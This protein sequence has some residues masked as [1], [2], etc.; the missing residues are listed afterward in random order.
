[1]RSL[2][3]EHT[4][5]RAI[6]DYPFIH[7]NRTRVL[8]YIFCEIG[9]SYKWHNGKIVCDGP[10][11]RPKADDFGPTYRPAEDRLR[12]EEDEARRR[13]EW[14]DFP[15]IEESQRHLVAEMEAEERLVRSQSKE[16]ARQT[17]D[18]P[19][20]YSLSEYSNLVRIPDDV[21]EPW[22]AM[23]EEALAMVFR[24]VENGTYDAAHLGGYGDRVRKAEARIAEI[25][26]ARGLTT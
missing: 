7:R 6:W 8:E 11:R 13:T 21:T 22:L 20:V 16:R 23:A 18:L 26:A 5:E 1:V 25:K 15:D 12:R 3:P 19:Y 4:I 9:G 24:A 17:D 14:A 10:R 2:T